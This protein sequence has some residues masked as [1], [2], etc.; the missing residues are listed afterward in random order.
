MEIDLLREVLE[1]QLVDRN[2]TYMGRVD[3]IVLRFEEGEQPQVDHLELGFVVLAR[4][5]HPRLEKLVEALRRRFPVRKTAIQIVPWS[6][7]GEID[8]HH[9]K[10]DMDAYD[11]PAFAWERWLR[12]R[13]VRKLPGA[14]SGED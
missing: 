5:V 8:R 12:D 6:L 13:I 14:S 9:V 2:G 3:G 1:M 4:R 7:V 11:T 10:V